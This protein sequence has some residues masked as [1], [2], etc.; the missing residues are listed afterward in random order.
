[1][2]RHVS[3]VVTQAQEGQAYALSQHPLFDD[4]AQV[5]AHLPPSRLA[6]FLDAFASRVAQVRNERLS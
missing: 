2:A 3:D 1:M 4:L 6:A 5:L